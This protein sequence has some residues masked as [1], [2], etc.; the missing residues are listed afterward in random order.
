MVGR[1]ADIEADLDRWVEA[2]RAKDFDTA[3]AIRE[4]LKAQG[5]D[6]E[7]E[8]P[9]NAPAGGSR[10]AT[11]RLL[12]Q[13]VD[14]K[15]AKDFATADSLR[16][17]LWSQGVDPEVARPKDQQVWVQPVVQAVQWASTPSRGVP[18]PRVPQQPAPRAKK[19]SAASE[20]RLDEWVEAKRAKDFSLADSIREELKAQGVDAEA[21]RPKD[22]GGGQAS[23]ASSR[24]I[25]QKLDAWVDAKRAKDFA[26]ADAIREELFALGVD[27]EW[28][29][30]KGGGI[31]VPSSY[32]T[33]AGSGR[34]G[35]QRYVEARL[36]EWVEAK[37]AKDFATADAI[38]EELYA[39]G[40]DAEVARPKGYGSAAID[41][42]YAPR[43]PQVQYVAPR[44]AHSNPERMLDDWV[45]AK[46]AKKFDVADK[47]RDKIWS[48]GID[49]EASRPS[50][51]QTEELLDQWVS[52]K[53]AKDFATAD[54]LRD[55]L[56]AQGVNAEE[57][58]PKG[59]GEP[60]KKR[61]KNE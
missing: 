36:D 58:R 47:L 3:D 6:A 16:E 32:G 51:K 43:V 61:V 7:T 39:Q 20:R 24:H 9:K 45:N 54:S 8:R 10:Q 14:A 12:D 11:E 15:R 34:G 42:V 55:A 13:W 41:T 52:A 1:K 18:A 50:H 57:A 35:G 30:P 56:A 2:K 5:V 33:S 25:Q 60:P 28:E 37:R 17:K 29:R 4:K 48:M 19:H 22:G 27:A 59:G 46:R 31:G 44:S 53:R 21:A 40:V 23:A 38:R 49:P 26:A